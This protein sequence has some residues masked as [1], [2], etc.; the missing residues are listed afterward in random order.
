MTHQLLAVCFEGLNPKA[1]RRKLI[2]ATGRSI[3]STTKVRLEKRAAEKAT[4]D[5]RHGKKPGCPGTQNQDPLVPVRAPS[6]HIA[7][8]F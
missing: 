3:T 6:Y 7:Q 4:L 2:V 8:V 5:T 1:T